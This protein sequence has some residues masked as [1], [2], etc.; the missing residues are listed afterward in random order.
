[1][2][3]ASSFKGASQQSVESEMG[4]IIPKTE[5]DYLTFLREELIRHLII[6]L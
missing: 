1:M 2:R 5:S 6:Q 3:K 4:K